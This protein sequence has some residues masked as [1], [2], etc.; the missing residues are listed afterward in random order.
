[1]SELAVSRPF[2]DV[3]RRIGDQ[4]AFVIWRGRDE[5]RPPVK[6]NTWWWIGW[7]AINLVALIACVAV[8]TEIYKLDITFML[9]LAA[10]YFAP[11]P[12]AF[13]LPLLAWRIS[14]AGLVLS[15]VA[16]LIPDSHLAGNQLPSAT[17]WTFPQAVIIGVVLAAIGLRFGA[18]PAAAAAAVTVLFTMPVL[19]QGL[20]HL[21]ALAVAT[22]LAIAGAITGSVLRDRRTAE[23]ELSVERQASAEVRAKQ[24]ALTERARIAR[25]LHDV[26]AHHMSMVAVRAE[27]APYRLSDV[28]EPARVEFTEIGSAARA[29]LAD[30]RNLLGV[31]RDGQEPAEMAPQPGAEQIPDLVRA[32]VAAGADVHSEIAGEIGDLPAA[33]GLAAYRIVQ[34]GLSNAGRHA[35]GA[36]VNVRVAYTATEVAIT[37][38]NGPPVDLDR[39]VELPTEQGAS[40]GLVGMR[41][42]VALVAGNFMAYPADR[43]GFVVEATLPRV[44]PKDGE[45]AE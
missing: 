7:A 33:V 21:D 15:L 30:M 34:E 32:A 5:S 31:L 38:R 42:R 35:P 1:M 37:I 3:T 29:A 12:L 19:T 27:T 2:H 24:A 25:E 9:V 41:E 39:T 4:I 11:L 6:H 17:S 14:L 22:V 44:Q 23:R 10:A 18:L 40:H 28:P 43:G 36:T 26:V 45:S 8:A 20:S 13:R 16:G